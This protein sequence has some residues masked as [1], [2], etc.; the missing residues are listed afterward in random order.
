MPCGTSDSERTTALRAET[1]S[2][3]HGWRGAAPREIV[4]AWE[5]HDPRKRYPNQYLVI[6]AGCRIGWAFTERELSAA[7]KSQLA[8]IIDAGKVAGGGVS[9][10]EDCRLSEGK[11]VVNATPKHA[12]ETFVAW[13]VAASTPETRVHGGDR[14]GP[15]D[16]FIGQIYTDARPA[17]A[18][19][20]PLRLE[21]FHRL[22]E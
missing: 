20:E 11:I 1:P 8:S 21:R 19:V 15:G 17:N 16:L 14:A 9:A 4:G 7:N 22:P 2:A 10:W 18:M 5:T 3:A 13:F 6:R 12:E